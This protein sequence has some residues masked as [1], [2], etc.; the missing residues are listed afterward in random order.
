MGK[1]KAK[2]YYMDKYVPAAYRHAGDQAPDQSSAGSDYNSY[3]PGSYR[4]YLNQGA[5]QGANS[6]SSAAQLAETSTQRSSGFWACALAG[7]LVPTAMAFAKTRHDAKVRDS[8][9]ESH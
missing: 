3:I 8:E 6:S 1:A 4:S 5:N 2:E 9:K 7:F